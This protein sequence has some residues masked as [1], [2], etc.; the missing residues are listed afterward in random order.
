MS[1][2]ELDSSQELSPRPTSRQ[3]DVRFFKTV[4]NA[5]VSD[6]EY[7]TEKSDE[8]ADFLDEIP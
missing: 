3:R 1:I 6:Q 4:Q 2:D 8:E 5:E 7:E